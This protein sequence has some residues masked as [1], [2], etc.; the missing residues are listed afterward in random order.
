[1]A[2]DCIHHLTICPTCGGL[3]ATRLNRVPGITSITFGDGAFRSQGPVT[4]YMGPA[5]TPC[6]PDTTDDADDA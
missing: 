5:F 4:V 3:D 1:M 6:N 2:D